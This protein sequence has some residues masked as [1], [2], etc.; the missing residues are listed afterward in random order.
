MSESNVERTLGRI[1]EKLNAA[2]QRQELTDTRLNHHSARISGLEK[3]Q[4]RVLGGAVVG[5]F[6][7]GV[8][9]RA[10]NL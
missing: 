10:L 8:L 2:L 4:S 6:V 7:L 5:G 1:E 3:W 9:M